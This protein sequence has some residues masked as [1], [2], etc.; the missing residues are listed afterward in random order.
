[1]SAVSVKSNASQFSIP[2][3]SDRC[4]SISPPWTI[5]DRVNEFVIKQGALEWRPIGQINADWKAVTLPHGATPCE[6]KAD[7]EDIMVSDTDG[8]IH[9]AKS[10]NDD[11]TLME[12][13]S[14]QKG[15]FDLPVI[16]Q[17][18]NAIV[19]QPNVKISKTQSWG[20]S[21]IESSCFY[22]D[23][24]GKEYSV[25]KIGATTTLFVADPKERV[26][27]YYDPFIFKVV[28][29][30]KKIFLPFP[31]TSERYLELLELATCC[32]GLFLI[33]YDIRQ[34]EGIGVEKQLSGYFISADAN[35]LGLQPVPFLLSYSYS[36]EKR[37]FV[38]PVSLYRKIN[39]PEGI[40]KNIGLERAP[41]TKMTDLVLTIESL[42]GY[43]WQKLGEKEWKFTEAPDR[44]K[45]PSAL[46]KP[47]VVD[48]EETF[49]PMVFDYTG[50]T[51]K[52]GYPATLHDFGHNSLDSKIVVD[53]A[54]TISEMHL[55]PKQCC[56]NLLGFDEIDYFLVERE[57]NKAIEVLVSIDKETGKVL[58]RKKFHKEPLFEFEKNLLKK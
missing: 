13:L 4:D 35:L 28:E 8:L 5:H 15:I 50:K 43:Y 46:L 41:G 39:L 47:V 20:C 23:A 57:A 58:I 18:Y 16:S 36:S 22:L 34:A 24:D 6:V 12:K 56:W 42:G 33:G 11:G 19:K 38:L 14:W 10:S 30:K 2:S 40:T 7:Y 48:S 32:S 1:M 25:G 49:T 54:G 53:K 51:K 44:K 37:K 3:S 52:E 29:E 31:E 45:E 55:Y 26:F 27:S 21:F 17:I 9:Y